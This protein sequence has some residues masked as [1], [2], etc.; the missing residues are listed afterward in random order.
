[1]KRFL[2]LV[3]IA[4]PFYS[5]AQYPNNSG[6]RPVYQYDNYQYDNSVLSIFSENGEPFYLILNGVK[7]N[8]IAQS[9]IRVEGLPKYMN[10]VQIMFADRT[11]PPIR[12]MVTIADPVDNKA[13]NLTLRISR[14]RQG[15]AKLK[16][17][18]MSECD[19]QYRGPRDEYVMYYGK[20]QQI[21]TVSETTYMDPITGQWVTE[22]TTT[23]TTDNTVGYGDRNGYGDRGR[24][25]YTRTGYNGRGGDDRGGYGGDRNN[26]PRPAGPVAMDSRTFSDLKSSI[27]NASFEDTKLSTAK[28]VLGNNYVTTDQVMEICNLFSF[29]NTKLTFAQFAY[30]KVIDKQNYFKVAS[31]MTFD[32]NKKALNDYISRQR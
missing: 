20:P 28:T 12:K 25:G 23:T 10:D 22:T 1:M 11:T 13:V 30:N 14:G 24:D 15:F 16:F 26:D 4:V 9:K 29:E 21:N 8:P 32:S 31:V 6:G 3:A 5:F 2:L 19:K 27:S 7:Q 18:R 17:H